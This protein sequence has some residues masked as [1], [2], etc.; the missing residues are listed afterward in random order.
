MLGS[1]NGDVEYVESCGWTL[2]GSIREADL[3]I[4]RGTFTIRDSSST[5]GS[6]SI[7]SKNEDE[8]AYNQ[9]LQESLTIAAERKVPM[10]VTNPDKV[11]PDKDPSPMPGSIADSYEKLL[12]GDTGDDDGRQLVKRIGKPFPEIYNLALGLECSASAESTSTS[13]I[14]VG[15]ALE[16]DVT[17]RIRADCSTGIF[18]CAFILLGSYAYYLKSKLDCGRIHLSD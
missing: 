14:M 4:A 13:A 2:V 18:A 8:E 15:D 1:G 3:I 9:M 10:L 16:T 11:R 6:G 17:G 7:I 5:N 12:G